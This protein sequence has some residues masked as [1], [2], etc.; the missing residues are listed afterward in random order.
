MSDFKSRLL[1][2]KEELD[3]KIVDLGLFLH[4]ETIM[5]ID[6]VKWLY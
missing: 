5:K 3:Q 1:N 2:E 4:G 6:P